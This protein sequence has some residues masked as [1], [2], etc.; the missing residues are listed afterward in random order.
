[1]ANAVHKSRIARSA[2]RNHK[3]RSPFTYTHG[4]S[5]NIKKAVRALSARALP[6]QKRSR[7][8]KSATV[9]SA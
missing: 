7:Y 3:R 4:T 5:N 8:S 2:N 9:P 6:I 1:M